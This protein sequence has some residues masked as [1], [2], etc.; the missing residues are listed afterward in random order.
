MSHVATEELPPWT[1]VRHRVVQMRVDVGHEFRS[2]STA[3]T[4]RPCPGSG[5]FVP[6]YRARFSFLEMMNVHR[7]PPCRVGATT[8]LGVLR[9][10]QLLLEGG[11]GSDL[12]LA[13]L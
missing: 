12:G 3:G 1:N 11:L 13:L 2:P 9:A 6:R 5:I 7:P 8:T 10:E 4:C